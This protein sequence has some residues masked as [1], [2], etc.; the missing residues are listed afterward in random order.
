M[1][2]IPVKKYPCPQLGCHLPNSPCLKPGG[3][4]RSLNSSLH[5]KENPI[6]VFLFWELHGLSP[7][8]HIHVSVI[9]LYIPRIG[10]HISLQPNRQTDP[11]NIYINVSQINDCR[12]W[13]TEHYNYVLEITVSFLGIH[14]REPAIC[15]GFSPALLLQR[16]A[17]MLIVV[18]IDKQIKLD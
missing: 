14:K 11:G 13:E 9:E 2:N 4:V 16:V 3:Q 10:P 1:E 7:S 15:I 8:F 12:N 5:C 18:N 17:C 6:Y